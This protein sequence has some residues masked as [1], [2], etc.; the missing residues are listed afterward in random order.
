MGTEVAGAAPGG[1]SWVRVG[2]ASGASGL[3]QLVGNG[4][5]TGDGMAGEWLMF[6]S[7]EFFLDMYSDQRFG[8]AYNEM[9][10]SGT[11]ERERHRERG[12]MREGKREFFECMYN[13][14]TVE[15]MTS[16]DCTRTRLWDRGS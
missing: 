5:A 12:R 9:W 11:S 4:F 8:F 3:V 14:T 16:N 13:D 10:D 15:N 6:S 2:L 7:C 1:F